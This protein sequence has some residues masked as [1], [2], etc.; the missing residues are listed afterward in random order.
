LRLISDV[1]GKYRS[2]PAKAPLAPAI[3]VVRQR[4]DNLI[5]LDQIGECRQEMVRMRLISLVLWA[6]AFSA[7]AAADGTLQPKYPPG[8]DCSAA[9][10]GAQRQACNR[11]QLDPPMGTIPDTT[12]Q[13]QPQFVVPPPQVPIVPTGRPRGVPPLPGTIDNSN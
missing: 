3:A 8:W 6:A 2:I 5:V 12:T 4:E 7:A 9:P 10:A 1:R 13:T 11:S